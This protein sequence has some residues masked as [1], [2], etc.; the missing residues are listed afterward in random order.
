MIQYVMIGLWVI[1]I[2]VTIIIEFESQD[3]VSIW[4]AIGAIGGLIAAALNIKPLLQI[5]IFLIISIILLFA[6]RPLTKKMTKRE[7]IPTNVDRYIGMV[8]IITKEVTPYQI[9]EIKVEN[10]L[11]RAT[12]LNNQSF[13][14]GE[15]ALIKAIS[16]TKLIINKM[17]ANIENLKNN[18]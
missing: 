11:W 8:G 17:N 1:F 16:G 10:S 7:R 5:G 4:F 18:K 13:E 3:L 14:V 12:N 2:I 9:G 6:T 15:K